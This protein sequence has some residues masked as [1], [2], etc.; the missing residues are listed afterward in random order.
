[1]K[2]TLSPATLT[3]VALG[4]MQTGWAAVALDV[5]KPPVMGPNT[6]PPLDPPAMLGQWFTGGGTQSPRPYEFYDNQVGFGGGFASTL[7]IN[8]IVTSITYSTGAGSSI[9][10]FQVAASITNDTLSPVTPWHPGNNS[11]GEIPGPAIPYQGTM[12]ATMLTIEFALTDLGNQPI[13]WIPPY[14]QMLPEIYATNETHAAWYCYEAIDPNT[15]GGYYVPAWDYGTIL[16]G[17]TVTQLLDF[18]VNGGMNPGDPRYNPLVASFTD[19]VSDIL[20]NRTTS[21]KISDWVDGIWVDN[22]F[23]YPNEDQ[24]LKN[25]NASVFFIPEAGVSGLL[26]L[27][28]FLLLRRRR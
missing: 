26:C 21:L 7:A 20:M 3:V 23:P 6:G 17:Q 16:P 10:A 1:M 5:T 15:P 12:F 2:K 8:G 24:A 22:G 14:T 25:S 27:T 18:V 4:M 19:Q 9:T 13:P 11:H 28:C